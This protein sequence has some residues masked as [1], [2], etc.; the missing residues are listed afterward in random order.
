MRNGTKGRDPS[1]IPSG[2]RSPRDVVAREQLRPLIKVV[3]GAMKAR[4]SPTHMELVVELL[5]VNLNRK[6]R[7]IRGLAGR[8]GRRSRIRAR[9]RQCYAAG[10]RVKHGSDNIFSERFHTKILILLDPVCGPGN[11]ERQSRSEPWIPDHE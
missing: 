1:W 6:Q 2:G 8:Q 11:R 5:R 9:D 3:I 7:A 4:C 10:S